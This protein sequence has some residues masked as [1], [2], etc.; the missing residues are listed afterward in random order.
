MAERRSDPRRS[1][2]PVRTSGGNVSSAAVARARL[3][4]KRERERRRK[5]RIAAFLLVLAAVCGVAAIVFF[6]GYQKVND[7]DENTVYPNIFVADVDLSGMTREE[8]AEAISRQSEKYFSTRKITVSYQ[9]REYDIAASDVAMSMDAE[10]AAAEAV[11]YGKDKGFFERSRLVR[12]KAGRVDIP[13]TVSFDESLVPEKVDGFIALVK[14]LISVANYEITDDKVVVDLSASGKVLDKAAI[15]ND[16]TALLKE[17]KFGAYT[18]EPVVVTP[19]SVDVDSI[20]LAVARDPQDAKLLY[21]PLDWT[22]ETAGEYDL[23]NYSGKKTYYIKPEVVGLSFDLDAARKTLASATSERV[24]EFPL[25][26]SYP[27]LTKSKLQDRIYADVLSTATTTLNTREVNRT[28]NVRLATEAVNGIELMPGEVF[29]YNDAVGPRT[30]KRGFKPA[31]TFVKGE[32]VDEIGGGIC[33]VSS[34]L[35]MATLKANLKQVSRSAH[36]FVVSYTPIGQDATVYWGS[37]DY[38]FKNDTDYPIRL[39]VTLDDDTVRI[40][41]VGTK[42][43]SYTYKLESTT[44]ETVP[45]EEETKY[46]TLSSAEAQEFGLTK[47][48]QKKVTGGKNGAKSSTYVIKLDAN[49]NE[50]DRTLAN[51]SSYR[52]STKITYIACV[53]DS[54]G[55]PILDADGKPIDP[56]KPAETDTET[57]TESET[58]T[59]EPETGTESETTTKEPDT[60]TESE[61][62]TKEPEQETGTGD[63]YLPEPDVGPDA[64]D[65]GPDGP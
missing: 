64:G 6:G 51:K 16:V 5:I 62:T 7:Y 65:P 36:R 27:E 46:V 39:K 44:D 12:G 19:Q 53:K 23:E 60:G 25:L 38:Q 47:I 37:L 35:Y 13:V 18:P 32:V 1:H 20:F 28:T 42:T 41:I 55:N 8:A 40:K 45:Y 33:Q 4:K 52:T 22:E 49:G 31:G 63:G 56:N 26:K 59:K 43:D 29:S 21:V 30:E 54:N 15:V 14:D 24:F 2:T 48:G 50:V 9:N 3:K 57:G 61:T 58:T 34:T 17:E 11:A 10:V